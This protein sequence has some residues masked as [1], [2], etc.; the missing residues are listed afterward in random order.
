MKK[1]KLELESSFWGRVFVM[2]K[3]RKEATEKGEEI[4]SKDKAGP[5]WWEAG[6]EGVTRVNKYNAKRLSKKQK[7]VDLDI[8][9][10]RIDV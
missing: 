10:I 1:Y 8:P 7:R 6:A 3:N 9:L 2:A 4:I 5:S